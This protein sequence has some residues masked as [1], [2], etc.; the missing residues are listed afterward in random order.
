MV[1][2]VITQDI[3]LDD[4]D[5]LRLRELGEVTAYDDLAKT[6]DDWLDRCKG[7][8]IICTGKFGLKTE[9]LYELQDV[10][11]ALP[12]VG[13]GFLDRE[14]L[15]K[16]NITVSYCPGCNKDAVSEWIIDLPA[17]INT[18]SLE[19]G[20]VPERTL[21]LTGKRVTIL[22]KG[23]IGLRVGEIC[24]CLGMA[25]YYFTRNDN[26][27]DSVKDSDIIINALSYNDET[28]NMLDVQFFNE[29]KKGSYF[30][31]VTS[32]GIFDTDAMIR[33]LESGILANAA[34]DAGSIQVGDVDDPYYQKLL[35]H[36]RVM[37]TPHIAYNSD[38]TDKVSSRM[39]IDNIKAWI[40]GE[41][42][43]LVDLS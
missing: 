23:N 38:T 34:I 15:K 20:K 18:S 5:I 29:L 11:L 31:S 41:P 27:R 36:P 21:G 37:V 6:P 33:A 32:S 14:R 13:V 1:K 7:A 3:G 25:V 35:N 39:L 42:K 40:C 4:E 30:I 28:K 10:F 26:L 8:D 24:K 17:M 9:K 12:F 43:N 22:G 2:I 16:N 19:T